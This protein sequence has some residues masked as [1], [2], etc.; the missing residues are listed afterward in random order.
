LLLLAGVLLVFVQGIPLPDALLS[1]LA[2]QNAR[3]LPLW[4]VTESSG[5]GLGGWHYL[6]IAPT[7]SRGALAVLM[8]YGLVFLVAVQRIETIEQV[9]RLLRWCALAAIGMAAFGLVQFFGGNGKFFW[10]HEHPGSTT[11]QAV[12]GSFTNR[13]HFAQFL[14][15]GIGPLIWW[16]QDAIRYAG[17]GGAPN[18]SM[19]ERPRARHSRP[20][21]SAFRVRSPE[22]SER[23][24]YLL[25]LGLAIVLFAGLLSLSRGGIAAL[26]V[27]TVIGTTVCCRATT[28]GPRFLAILAVAVVL[29]GTSLAVFGYNR[30]ADR[31]DTLSSGSLAELDHGRGRRMIWGATLQSIPNHWFLGTGAASFAEVYPVY[32]DV[33]VREEVEFTHGENCYL[34]I[35]LETGMVGLALVVVGIALCGWWSYRGLARNV[36]SRVQLCAGATAASLAASVVHAV[37]DFVWYVPACVVMVAILAAAAARLRQMADAHPGRHQPRRL[38]RLAWASAWLLL[39]LTGGWMVTVLTGP[40]MAASSW[41][42]YRL[43]RAATEAK[44][45]TSSDDDAEKIRIERHWIAQ[46]EEV[47]AWQPTHAR[48]HL[49]LAD[50]HLR[51]FDLIQTTAPNPMSLLNVRDAVIQSH[52]DSYQAM[53]A[54]LSRAIGDHR[55]HLD[56]AL[57]HTRQ[58]IS[59]CP[60]LGRGY[61]YLA[62]LAFLAPD[63]PPFSPAYLEQALRVRPY[64]GTVL[65][66][67]ANEAYLAGDPAKWLDLGRRAFHSGRRQQQQLITMLLGQTTDENVPIMIDFIVREFQPDLD[68]LRFLH[69]ECGKRREAEAL[70]P[71]ARYRAAYAESEASGRRATAAAPLWFEAFQLYDQLG[72]QDEAL[73]C[74]QAAVE[75]DP[76]SYPIHFQLALCLLKQQR[77]VEAESHLRWCQQRT[78][79]SP[80]VA[81][82]LRETLKG[83]LDAERQAAVQHSPP[84]AHQR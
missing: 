15:L 70:V 61:V 37:V 78:P 28:L 66:G 3:W 42:Q 73:R 23:T 19:P 65:Y 60:L 64:D 77:F 57:H 25:G 40:A 53:T 12:K 62:E 55:T 8:A 68:G 72:Q 27:A 49:E 14:A 82:K 24:A 4:H 20:P 2:P 67:A 44:R 22:K 46:L 29:I 39:L 6:S 13:N 35:A 16:L 58:A 34:P 32:S 33:G 47:V 84:S 1:W 75:C 48:G 80:S 17:R 9:E 41:N 79:N 21:G 18:H 81:S 59:L 7:E 5:M 50:A 43:D 69:A 30:V 26:L 11:L 71:L 83:R 56:Q 54:W 51:L 45:K 38:P 52:F 63:L 74:A 31:L 76:S 10:F 36:P